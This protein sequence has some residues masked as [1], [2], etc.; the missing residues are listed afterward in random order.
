M[1][2][3]PIHPPSSA[4]TL[5]VFGAAFLSQVAARQAALRTINQEILA[6]RNAFVLEIGCGHGHMLSAYAAAHPHKLCI[7]IDIIADRIDRANRKKNRARLTNLHFLHA[8]A[9]DF[10]PA[11]P[12]HLFISELF[13]LFPDPWPKRR[14]HK[15]R[16]LQPDFLTELRPRVA[17][18]SRLYF[19]TDDS[20]YFSAVED[21]IKAH[22]NWTE[23]KDP[24]AFEHVTVFQDRALSHQSLV[25]A[26]T[27]SKPG[28]S[29]PIY[30]TH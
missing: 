7:G 24:W 5:T 9:E 3:N 19:R 25:A 23:T 13:V 21:T 11:L 27:D 4:E 30:R 29:A 14:H 16:L 28:N 20:S 22:P 18:D 8:S 26:P 1:E 10:I 15:N 17:S 12:S 2:S 6:G